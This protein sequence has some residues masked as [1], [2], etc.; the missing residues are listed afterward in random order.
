MKIR[1][2]WRVFM[3]TRCDT[4]LPALRQSL[5]VSSFLETRES[6]RL[7]KSLRRQHS[8]LS[9]LKTLSVGPAGMFGL[10]TSCTA[11]SGSINWTNWSAVKAE[12]WK[13]PVP[14]AFC[15]QLKT[16]HTSPNEMKLPP[17]SAVENH[18]PGN[19]ARLYCFFVLF[20]FFVN[21]ITTRSHFYALGEIY[22][23]EQRAW[24]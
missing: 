13:I 3:L 9:H 16:R 18:S 21:L 5:T 4:E 23:K 15:R 12:V 2:P 20:C 6:N 19:F 10:S 8:L 1:P 7:Q 11:A 22:L 24:N 14:F 17:Q